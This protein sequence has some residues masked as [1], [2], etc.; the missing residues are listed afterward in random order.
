MKAL[1]YWEK[2]DVVNYL[3]EN[4]LEIEVEF[5]TES[6]VKKI[7][8][9]KS[10]SYGFGYGDRVISELLSELVADGYLSVRYISVK[11][12]PSVDLYWSEK[13]KWAFGSKTL[14]VYRMVSREEKIEKI[15][16]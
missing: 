8:K 15:L 4:F 5:T 12:E 7:N 13:P 6:L 9:S 3:K 2:H 1:W 14:A 16:K 11:M 10:K